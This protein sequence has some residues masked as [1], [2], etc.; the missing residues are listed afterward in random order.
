LRDGTT[1]RVIGGRFSLPAAPRTYTV[2]VTAE[3]YEATTLEGVEVTADQ[4][5]VV[6]IEL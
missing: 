2:I 1:N 5:T 4:E 6:E 3:G